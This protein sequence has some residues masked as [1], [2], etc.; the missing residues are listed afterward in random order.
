MRKLFCVLILTSLINSSCESPDE[1]IPPETT[2]T[3]SVNAGEG[4]SVSSSGGSYE[5][6]KVV[7]ITAT[8]S[9]EY[10]FTAWSNG[11]TDNPIAIIVD[12]NKTISANFEKRKYPLT[13]T[14]K[15]KGTVTEEVVSSGKITTEYHSGSSIRLTAIPSG[16]WNTFDNWSGDIDS[17]SS[18]IELM[19][20]EPKHITVTFQE[21]SL[22]V[23][24]NTTEILN[25]SISTSDVWRTFYDVSGVFPYVSEGVQ[26]MFYP[27]TAESTFSNYNN[28]KEEI[29]RAHV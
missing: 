9:S 28:T 11:S 5:S 8:P 2:Y 19:I 4:G 7:T 10:I 3:L 21:S 14:I 20:N 17:Q 27:G 1:V 15:G 23:V 24:D 22:I 18:V 13:I 29:G 12:A 25:S 26:Y 16:E 6:G